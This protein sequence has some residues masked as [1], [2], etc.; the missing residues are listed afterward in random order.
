[1]ALEELR[2]LHLHPKEVRSRLILLYWVELPSHPHSDTLPPTRP[3]LL[4]VTVPKGQAYSNHH[5][6]LPTETLSS[7]VNLLKYP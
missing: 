6:L 5:I 2:T 1:M 4:T 7:P 3:H